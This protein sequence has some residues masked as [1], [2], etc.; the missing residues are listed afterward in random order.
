[1]GKDQSSRRL[2]IYYYPITEDTNTQDI[3]KYVDKYSIDVV[4]HQDL[5]INH[6]KYWKDGK[7]P[8]Y[9]QIGR[10][11]KLLNKEEYVDAIKATNDT[12][13]TEELL[14][15]LFER[16][17]NIVSITNLKPDSLARPDD[18]DW[19]R[20][21]VKR[22]FMLD[23]MNYESKLYE[24]C[25]GYTTKHRG[26]KILICLRHL[27]LRRIYHPK[28]GG[29]SPII[30]AVLRRRR[31]S[32][33]FIKANDILAYNEEIY[34]DALRWARKFRRYYAHN[35]HYIRRSRCVYEEFFIERRQEHLEQDIE[36][37]VE[38][39]DKESED[40]SI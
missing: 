7:T 34:Q 23:F 31:A 25:I 9:V 21:G 22:E 26:I 27:Q 12:T 11:H 13:V 15:E 6:E 32:L 5:V 24:G 36:V 17:V 28:Y 3:L 35:Y 16:N 29:T 8:P 18:F 20:V 14:T 37:D 30:G 38:E 40:G 1:M 4:L 2:T 33:Y 19:N 39:I 10:Y